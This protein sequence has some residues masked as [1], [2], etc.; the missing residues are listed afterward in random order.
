M[1]A[2]CTSQALSIDYNLVVLG[3]VPVRQI[4]QSGLCIYHQSPLVGT[5]CAQTIAAVL[6]HEYAAAHQLR[7]HLRNRDT[8]SNVS[9]ITVEHQHRRRHRL[10]LVRCADEEGRELL[11]VG[12]GDLEVFIVVDAVVARL[13]D[14]GTGIAG[15]VRWV[16]EGSERV[17]CQLALN[18]VFGGGR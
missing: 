6:Q 17:A 7:Y 1:N 8:V 13:G 4:V 18:W 11:A 5:T 15:D 12:C 14:L 3:L 9:G 16:D 2:D 10:G